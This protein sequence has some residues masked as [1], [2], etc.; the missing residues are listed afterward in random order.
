MEA[1]IAGALITGML[2][3]CWIKD[4]EARQKEKKEKARTEMAMTDAEKK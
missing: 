4:I 2:F 3:G 1:I